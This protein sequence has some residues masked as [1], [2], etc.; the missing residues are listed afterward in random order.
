M[1]E[2]ILFNDS[3]RFYN[4]DIEMLP[5]PGK[6]PS[7]NQA[8]TEHHLGGPA[9]INYPDTPAD[10]GAPGREITLVNWDYVTLPH[11]YMINEPYVESCNNSWG[12]K[13]YHPAWYRKHFTIGSEDRGKRIVLY[14]EGIADYATVYFNG[15]DMYRSFES[16]TPFEVDLTDFVRF[17]EDNVLAIRTECGT[18]EG[19][20]YQGGGIYRNVWLEKKPLLSV[21]RYGVYVAPVLPGKDGH[22]LPGINE[23]WNVPVE[24][25][26]RNDD[27]TEKT[28]EIRC[29]ILAPDGSAVSET[30]CIVSAAP[31]AKET[32][33]L[34]LYVTDPERWDEDHPALYT[35]CTTVT[36]VDACAQ[37]SAKN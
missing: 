15:S 36:D 31:R 8:K 6:G 30:A 28:A 3:W 33:K 34:T 18:G 5:S 25:T 10:N 7:Y 12:Y 19:W 14:F 21:D 1:S 27:Y 17:D 9:S 13:P 29:R 22:D 2:R 26:V 16:H 24:V 23:C 20:W 11:D 37:V 4:A 32:A 35:L